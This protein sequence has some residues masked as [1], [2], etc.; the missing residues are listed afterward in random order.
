M[1]QALKIILYE[2]G[3]CL[4]FGIVILPLT[5]SKPREA[6]G[7]L[8]RVYVCA[9]GGT[10]CCLCSTAAICCTAVY[11]THSLRHIVR[12]SRD[13]VC[14]DLSHRT[15]MDSVTDVDLTFYMAGLP[16]TKVAAICTA[17]ICI[18]WQW[19]W[20]WTADAFRPPR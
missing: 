1:Q 5:N 10:L 17:M 12:R 4:V 8:D 7:R 13:I 18:S 11:I 9:L 14:T 19:P 3:F 20:F 6:V 16:G 2:T 15:F